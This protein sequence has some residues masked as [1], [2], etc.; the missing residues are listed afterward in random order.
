M[1]KTFHFLFDKNY[2]KLYIEQMFPERGDYSF[3]PEFD[4][5]SGWAPID[6]A[7]IK[8]TR[9][10]LCHFKAH[11]KGKFYGYKRKWLIFLKRIELDIDTEKTGELDLHI[12]TFTSLSGAVIHGIANK[13]ITDEVKRQKIKLPKA[14]KINTDEQDAYQHDREFW[15][16]YRGG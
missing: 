16:I 6:G 13:A 2:K 14:K 10:D 12:F 4:R 3:D 5:F 1:L 7:Y 8:Y 11:V 15:R 9:L